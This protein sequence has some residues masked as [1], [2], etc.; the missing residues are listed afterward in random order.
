MNTTLVWLE[1]VLWIPSKEWDAAIHHISNRFAR[2]HPLD[3]DDVLSLNDFHQQH[4]A[5]TIWSHNAKVDLDR[6]LGRFFDEHLAIYLR[7][8]PGLTRRVR[9]RASNSS[10]EVI[11][12]LGKRSAESI[13]RHT[14]YWRSITKLIVCPNGEYAHEDFH[15]QRPVVSI[16]DL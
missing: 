1:G 6:E 10:I 4:K 11:T 9:V 2:A 7:P 15:D 8:D 3:S 14:G 5:L 13:L 12:A 16:D